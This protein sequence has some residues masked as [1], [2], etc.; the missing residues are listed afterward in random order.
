MKQPIYE[1]RKSTLENSNKAEDFHFR[2]AKGL[3]KLEYTLSIILV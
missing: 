1:Q 2:A 3:S